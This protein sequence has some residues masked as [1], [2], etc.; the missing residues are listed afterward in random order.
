MLT[1]A[2]ESDASPLAVLPQHLTPEALL[3]STPAAA[4]RQPSAPE[5]MTSA[6]RPARP[7]ADSPTRPLYTPALSALLDAAHHQEQQ[8]QQHP[9]VAAD[10]GVHTPSTG[11][12]GW[13]TRGSPGP[14]TQSPGAC[15][16]AT[17]ALRTTWDPLPGVRCVTI[18]FM[19]CRAL[20]S[21]P[22]TIAVWPVPPDGTG[23]DRCVLLTLS[24][25]L[26]GGA[27]SGQVNGEM[28]RP[29]SSKQPCAGMDP[30]IAKSTRTP[31]CVH[32]TIYYTTMSATMTQ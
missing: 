12:A 18:C 5:W 23:C 13:L 6:R 29:A 24:G 28:G 11:S 30:S 21:C 16:Q 25:S 15:G 14:W 1:V 19:V 32:T 26:A 2:S 27:V 22:C 9:E 17:P 20:S 3:P 8:Q 31:Y 7:A 4:D 10:S